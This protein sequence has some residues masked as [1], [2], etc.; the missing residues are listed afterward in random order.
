M[1]KIQLHEKKLLSAKLLS[2]SAAAGAQSTHR[3]NDVVAVNIL[4]SYTACTRDNS[5]WIIQAILWMSHR[6]PH[7]LG[8]VFF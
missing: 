4:Q 8:V 1:K 7:M 2:Y 3:I 5:G 6:V